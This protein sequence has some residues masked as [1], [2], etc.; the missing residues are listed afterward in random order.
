MKNRTAFLGVFCALA[1]V[2]GYLEALI[3]PFTGIPGM[4]LGLANI[5]VISVMYM[6]GVKEAAIVSAVRILVIGA[7]FGS[8]ISI[9]YSFCGAALSIFV[10]ALLK[11]TGKFS[12]RGVSIAGGVSHNIGQ[13]IVAA[14]V[15]ETYGVF[16][17]MPF[18]IISGVV[19]GLLI[20]L[21]G[22]AITGRMKGIWKI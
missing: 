11:R 16:Y 4:K 9:L 6:T 15:V 7:L 20:G 19:T 10:M 14:A 8:M 12:I 22:G 2:L 18:L 1:V 3:P 17:Y 21:L 5:A 13:L